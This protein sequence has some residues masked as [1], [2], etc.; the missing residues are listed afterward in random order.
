M[1]A[2]PTMLLR[3]KLHVKN[4]FSRKISLLCNA[5]RGEGREWGANEHDTRT[6]LLRGAKQAAQ[7]QASRGTHLHPVRLLH[8]KSGE[9]A[10]A[11]GAACAARQRRR[12]RAPGRANCDSS[13]AADGKKRRHRAQRESLHSLV[14]QEAGGKV[15]IN[16]YIYDKR[17]AQSGAAG[18]P[19]G[20]RRA[21]RARRR[22]A[23]RRAA[24]SWCSVY[25]RSSKISTISRAK[26][27]DAAEQ[28]AEKAPT[29]ESEKK[30]CA[31]L[32]RVLRCA[33][34]KAQ[35]HALSPAQSTRSPTR[36]PAARLASLPSAR[37][38]L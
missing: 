27:S 6:R 7:A 5:R 25:A 4:W 21:A 20:Q 37:W 10:A 14:R 31:F 22:R 11:S 19:G 18:R 24:R 17:R 8:F 28:K 38:A 35:T 34:T 16:V 32:R 15:K 23:R 13:G 1:T 30:S 26:M 9:L 29:R 36:R 33:A 12:A 2:T 3:L